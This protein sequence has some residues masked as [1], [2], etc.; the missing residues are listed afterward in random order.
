MDLL[1][2][3]AERARLHGPNETRRTVCATLEALTG[4][5]PPLVLH[6]LLITIPD[7]IR[8]E[9]PVGRAPRLRNCREFITAIAGR[10]HVEEPEAAFR[11]RIIFEQLND[12]PYGLTPASVAHLTPRDMRPLLTA[13]DPSRPVAAVTP[14]VPELSTIIE[15]PL[16]ARELH[17]V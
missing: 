3:I 8:R 1:T 10:L 16:P 7:G 2:R 17:P 12:Q 11:A 15:F 4:V 14:R 5:L 13:R 9:L 6:P